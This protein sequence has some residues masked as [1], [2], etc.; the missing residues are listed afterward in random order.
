M[1]LKRSSKALILIALC[2]IS[3]AAVQDTTLIR[4]QLKANTVEKFKVESTTKITA[5]TPAGLQEGTANTTSTVETTI[6]AVKSDGSNADFTILT[7][8]EKMTMEG[9]AGAPPLPDKVPPVTMRGTI[10][11]MN[12]ATA[13]KLVGDKSATLSNPMSMLGGTEASQVGL[14][15]EFPEKAVKVGDV[16]TITVPPSVMT[17]KE[18]TI[19][20]AT[21]TGKEDVDG[22]SALVVTLTGTM[23]IEPDMEAMKKANQNGAAD[24][25]MGMDIKVKGTAAIS[26]KNWIDPETGATL[27]SETRIKGQTDV[28]IVQISMTMKVG[29]DTTV[30]MKHL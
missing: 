28:E 3:V 19:L 24:P 7:T 14:F 5:D 6:G 30:K 12:R 18:P 20:T 25:T 4:R 2:A 8:T 23:K 11:G 22:K 13:M 26:T 10:D 29:T 1:I 9:M 15:V 16:W 17:G 21:Y 27:K